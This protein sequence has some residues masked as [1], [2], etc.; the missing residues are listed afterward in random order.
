MELLLNTLWLLLALGSLAICWRV[1]VRS[2]KEGGG[3]RSRFLVLAGSLLA[4]LFPTVSATDDLRAL[5]V[6]M[7]EPNPAKRVIKQLESPKSPMWG[8]GDGPAQLPP[9]VSVRRRNETCGLTS[10][11]LPALREHAVANSVGCRA[12]PTS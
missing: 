6:V 10:R 7:E 3:T 1:P 4:L 12:P 9:V 8:D 11:Y 5:R 2:S